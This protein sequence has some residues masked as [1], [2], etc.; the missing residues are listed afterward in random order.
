MEAHERRIV[1]LTSSAHGLIHIFMLLFI[2]ANILMAKELGV[3]LFY[4]GN[5]G[6][7]SYFAFGLGALPAG[8]LSDRIGSH[9]IITLCL[10]GAGA[11]SF[12]ISRSRGPVG[13]AISLACLGVFASL[14]HPAALSL[15][16]STV[17]QRGKAL[18]IHGGGGNVGLALS[19]LIGGFIASHYGWR[20]G[21]FIFSLVGIA[22]GIM[23]IRLKTLSRH[24]PQPEIHSDKAK[25]GGFRDV[26]LFLC[27][28]YM[29]QILIGLIYRG[30]MVF[31]PTYLAEKVGGQLWGT[32]QIVK[33]GLV[34]TAALLVGVVGQYLGGVWSPRIGLEKLWFILLTIATPFLFLIGLT[35]NTGLIIVAMAFAF[36]HFSCQPVGN[37]L[38]A[39]YTSSRIRSRG[40][41][42][43]FFLSA[44]VGSFASSLA[45]WLGERSGLSRIFVVLGIFAIMTSVLAITLLIL[46]R[47]RGYL[48]RD[49]Y[50]STEPQG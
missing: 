12:F 25:S 42:I 9:R 49:A 43:S 14:Y 31:L 8:F 26:A 34:A 1:A 19:P 20:A 46:A 36:F 44:G 17:K 15:I 28:I 48:K 18:G 21:Y 41:G 50:L 35:T 40:Y 23:S 33:G 39:K 2:T 4:I 24:Q 3:G 13:L 32:E 29:V 11:S 30:S 6:T 10:I 47:K 27:L 22:L 16:S 45:G 37:G 7:I 38:I 5:L